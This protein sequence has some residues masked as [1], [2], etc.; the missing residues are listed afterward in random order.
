MGNFIAPKWSRSR[1]F[2][3]APRPPS[4][5]LSNHGAVGDAIKDPRVQAALRTITPAIASLPCTI[6]SIDQPFHHTN[7][8]SHRI[9]RSRSASGLGVVPASGWPGTPSRSQKLR[10]P[11]SGSGYNR[12]DTRTHPNTPKSPSKCRRHRRLH[13]RAAC[14]IEPLELVASNGATPQ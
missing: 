10:R 5:L 14:A 4:L 1:N 6:A 7:S 3:F 12:F 8:M 2:P 9:L 13:R 11:L